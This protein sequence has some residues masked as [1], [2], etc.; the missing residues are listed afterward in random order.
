MKEDKLFCKRSGKPCRA[1]D[2]ADLKVEAYIEYRRAYKCEFC[3]YWHITSRLRRE[4][5][6]IHEPQER[7]VD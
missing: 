4:D 6:V 2:E 5:M 1:K 7:D 3:G